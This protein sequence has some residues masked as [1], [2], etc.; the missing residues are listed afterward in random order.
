MPVAV[1]FN[2][3]S[4]NKLQITFEVDRDSS[5]QVVFVSFFSLLWYWPW[6]FTA[7]FQIKLWCPI[8]EV[9]KHFELFVD[10]ATWTVHLPISTWAGVKVVSQTL[11]QTQQLDQCS[12]VNCSSLFTSRR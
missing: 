2:F 12:S 6:A 9:L 4:K 7:V 3:Y 1:P 10:S 8:S 5:C 11:V